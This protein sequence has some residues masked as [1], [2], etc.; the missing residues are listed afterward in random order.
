LPYIGHSRLFQLFR[1]DEPWDSEHNR[2]LIPFMPLE[3]S[4]SVHGAPAGH[5]TLLAV[6]GP[7]T[8]FPGDRVIRLHDIDDLR[9]DTLLAVEVQ[10]KFAVEWTKPSDFD[11][12]E[13]A[14]V[15]GQLQRVMSN[16]APAGLAAPAGIPLSGPGVPRAGVPSNGIATQQQLYAIFADFKSRPVADSKDNQQLLRAARI[17]DR[18]P[19]GLGNSLSPAGSLGR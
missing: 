17:D 5:T 4:P 15:F 12:G 2:K 18:A 6:S 16:Q 9:S 14:T 13:D 3:Y 7:R 1:L 10:P 8:A 11:V 19:S